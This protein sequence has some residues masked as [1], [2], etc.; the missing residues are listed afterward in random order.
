MK[1]IAANI[2]IVSVGVFDPNGQGLL[3]AEPRTGKVPDFKPRQ[4][5][6]QKK[7]IKLMTRPVQLGVAA[8]ASAI[9]QYPQWELV[10]PE[11][12]AFFVGAAPQSMQGGLDRAFDHS[13]KGDCFSLELFATEGVSHIHPLWL[14]KGLSNNILGFASSFW[15]CQG[16]NSNY[17][18]GSNGGWQAIVEG[19][20]ALEEEQADIVLMGGADDMQA[21]SDL[22]GRE[23]S[24]AAVFLIAKRSERKCFISQERLAP[25][26]EGYGQLGAVHWPLALARAWHDEALKHKH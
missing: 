3:Q 16:V 6:P 5:I 12:R 17:C 23:G 9:A 10:K 14:V 11:R 19:V 15:D 2:E 22:I 7:Q 21:A 8:A 20:Y 13:L 4:W 25:Y 24:E 26:V 18:D 1:E